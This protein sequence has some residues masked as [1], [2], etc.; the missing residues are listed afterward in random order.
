MYIYIV[1]EVLIALF[2]ESICIY[3]YIY[4]L[5]HLLI[6]ENYTLKCLY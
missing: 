2:Y 3:L 5:K 4:N 6:F 1:K